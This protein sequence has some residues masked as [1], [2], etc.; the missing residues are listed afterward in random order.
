MR[1]WV[2]VRSNAESA[3]LQS[4]A[5]ELRSVGHRVHFSLDKPF[6][7]AEVCD[8]Y[9]YD[10]DNMEI[11]EAYE[12]QGTPMFSDDM[13]GKDIEKRTPV[14]MPEAKPTSK[15]KAAKKAPKK[16]SKP[17]EPEKVEGEE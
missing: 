15:K 9:R 4:W 13:L 12:A 17:A 8:A 5:K 14:N 2:Y 16:E 3:E 7:K 10:G 1:I 11:V 6:R